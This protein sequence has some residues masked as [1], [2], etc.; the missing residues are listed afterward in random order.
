MFHSS[1]SFS[2]DLG[3][4]L[5]RG[6]LSAGFADVLRQCHFLFFVDEKYKRNIEI[7][8]FF[9]LL[10]LFILHLHID[11]KVFRRCPKKAN[12]PIDIYKKYISF[13]LTISSIIQFFFGQ[14]YK[15]HRYCV[16]GI[17]TVISNFSF[18]PWFKLNEP[19]KKKWACLEVFFIR[20][21]SR[22]N[23]ESAKIL[24]FSWVFLKIRPI[25][26]KL[27]LPRF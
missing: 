25:M 11:W 10:S 3:C 18:V 8:I 27:C 5:L 7:T 23:S 12:F 21:G 17:F 13:N 19:L 24:D 6:R 22:K 26:G 20:N 1:T 4:P 9:P 2:M 15:L 14:R 16:F